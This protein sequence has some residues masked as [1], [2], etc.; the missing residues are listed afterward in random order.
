MNKKFKLALVQIAPMEEFLRLN[1]EERLRQN[2]LM[3]NR[4]LVLED[5]MEQVYH[6][7]NFIRSQHVNSH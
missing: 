1:V 6:G 4:L 3:A 7:W 2:D 5:F